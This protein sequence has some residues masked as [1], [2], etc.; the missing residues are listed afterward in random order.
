MTRALAERFGTWVVGWNN[1]THFGGPVAAW[2][3][4]SR[5]GLHGD[6]ERR[7]ADDPDAAAELAHVTHRLITRPPHRTTAATEMTAERRQRVGFVEGW[8]GHVDE[9]R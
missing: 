7:F 6:T 4:P 3:C 1:S 9:P 2:C 8:I 5:Y